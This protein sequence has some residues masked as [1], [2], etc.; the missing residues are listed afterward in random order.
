V[1][2]DKV[3]LV[4]VVRDLAQGIHAAADVPAVEPCRSADYTRGLRSKVAGVDHL[5]AAVVVG[6]VIAEAY[7][8]QVADYYTRLEAEWVLRIQV[9][10]VAGDEGCM[11]EE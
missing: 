2:A 10:D 6:T 9:G 7:D 4:V 1:G 8:T 5:V 3:L 11:D